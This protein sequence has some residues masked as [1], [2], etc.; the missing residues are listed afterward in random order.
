[1][2]RGSPLGVRL[3]DGNL[4]LIAALVWRRVG[5]EGHQDHFLLAASGTSRR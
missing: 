2:K 1:V 5:H 4:V 3:F